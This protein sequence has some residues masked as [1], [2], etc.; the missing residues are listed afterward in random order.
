MK[1]LKI[2]LIVLIPA[3]GFVSCEKSHTM[4]GGCKNHKSAT[5]NSGNSTVTDKVIGGSA[6]DDN[7]GS[8][9]TIV[10]SGDDDR[11]GGDKKKKAR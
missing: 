2:L 3:L 11:D 9:T 1:I 4:P 10:G 6:I 8:G 7:S 5:P